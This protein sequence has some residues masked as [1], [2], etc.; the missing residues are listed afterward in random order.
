MTTAAAS[1]S[2]TIHS[3][4][5]HPVINRAQERKWYAVFT[6]PQSEK[7]VVKHLNLRNIESYLPTYE[8]LHV[9]KNRQRKTIQLPLFPAYLFVRITM[10]ERVKVLQSPG[11][12][13]IVGT[14]REPLPLP[15]S[16]IEFLRTGLQG[17]K[18]E[19]Y[20]ELLVGDRVRVKS[21]LMQGVQG[22][23]V[24]QGKNLRFVLT[25]EL[26]NQHAAV[27]VDAQDLEP[28]S[29]LETGKYHNSIHVVPKCSVL[30][31]N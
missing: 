16:E 30:V 12:I 7:S 24:G 28:V 23:L 18:V 19:P 8:A 11:V 6:F 27:E 17:R 10:Q 3:V 9:W 15:D 21:G 13:L 20:T 26:I 22:T 14:S 25:L 4:P 1:E 31:P 29:F 2:L 5:F